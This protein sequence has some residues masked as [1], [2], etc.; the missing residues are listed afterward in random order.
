MR[1]NGDRGTTNAGKH[2]PKNT[3]LL[4]TPRSDVA[5]RRARAR[6]APRVLPRAALYLS[7]FSASA[8]VFLF[9][10]FLV[11][12]LSLVVVFVIVVCLVGCNFLIFNFVNNNILVSFFV[13]AVR[14]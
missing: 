12:F 8:V 5:T 14:A 7:L 10:F 6:A 2:L 4:V 1:K 13:T 9:F 3:S 11:F